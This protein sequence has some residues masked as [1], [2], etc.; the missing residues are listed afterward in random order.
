MCLERCK[1]PVLTAT[2]LLL[3]QSAIFI[4]LMVS[5]IAFPNGP[6]TRPHPLVWR[7]VLGVTVLYWLG[8]VFCLFQSYDDIRYVLLIIC[9]IIELLR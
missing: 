1:R 7:L 9:Q 4:F 8:L 5:L 6:F 3:A 2:N